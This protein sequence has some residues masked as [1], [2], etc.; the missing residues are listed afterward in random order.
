M[1]RGLQQVYADHSRTA[2]LGTRMTPL[3]V[4]RSTTFGKRTAEEEREKLKQYF[5]ETEQWRRV[6]SGY[7]DIVYGP[8][9]SGKSAI[10]SLIFENEEALLER[11]IVAA[12]AENPQGAPAFQNLA[13]D[14]P[15]SEFEFASLWKLYILTLCGKAIKDAGFAGQK[16]K[17]LLQRLE[18]A[19][20]LPFQFTLSKAV[21]Y[22]LDYVR[23]LADLESLEAGLKIDPATGFPSGFTGKI[24]LREPS[25]KDAKLGVV[26]LDEL[27]S[28]AND[29]LKE[30]GF[31]L[32]ILLDRLDVAFADRADLELQALRSLFQ[33]YLSNKGHSNINLKIFLRTDIWERITEGGFREASHIERSLTIRLKSED[34]VNMIGKRAIANE[35]ICKH[36]AVDVGNI[37][38]SYG[39]QERFIYKMFPH[40]VD[41]SPNKPGTMTW[42]LSRTRDSIQAAAPREVIHFLNELRDVQIARLERGERPPGEGRLFEQIAFKE[43]LPAVSKV[44]LEQTMFA[45]YPRLKSRIIQLREQKATQNLKSLSEIWRVPEQDASE[46]VADL[47]RVGFFERS[48]SQ[49]RVPFLYR[50]A[51]DLI[52]GSADQ[53]LG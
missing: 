23:K 42:I 30:E 47:E 26:S 39:E 15:R 41:S 40:Q 31:S 44:R 52:Q 38:S 33:F 21:R 6:L 12:P 18:E 22:V 24:A 10:Y 48:G 9:G 19:D 29:A 20:L 27:Y 13:D 43:A 49:W 32:W 5:V 14:P 16:S 3:E 46:I 36:Y 2:Y 25:A 53:A 7:V 28:I 34:I 50:P 51:L 8:K 17:A 45:E 1:I 4:L 37:T 11:N 35:L